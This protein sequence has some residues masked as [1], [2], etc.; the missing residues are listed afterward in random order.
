MIRVSSS[1]RRPGSILWSVAVSLWIAGSAPALFAA[2][3]VPFRHDGKT[4]IDIS[5]D[6]LD[7]SQTD[8]RAV[9][10]G[11]VVAIQGEVRLTAEKM[12][13]HY[14]KSTPA[15]QKKQAAGGIRK[16]EVEKDVFLSTPGETASGGRGV[17]DVARQQIVLE[18]NVVLT[19]DKNTLKGER[20][21]YDFTTGKSALAS[22][23]PAAPEKKARVRALFV[24]EGMEKKP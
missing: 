20:L 16:I 4:P 24:P 18:Q 5:A 12:I 10:T 1:R 2:D 22:H 7:I 8:G 21:V 3:P 15:D 11:H 13:V 9:F 17:Y 23:D 14:E 6:N 19:K